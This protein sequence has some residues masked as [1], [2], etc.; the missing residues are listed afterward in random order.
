MGTVMAVM[1]AMASRAKNSKRLLLSLALLAPV[2]ASAGDWKF[3]SGMTLSERYSD[4]VNLAVTG[5]ERADWITEVTPSV[6]VRREGARLKVN[7]DYSLQGLLYADDANNNK[8]R[9]SLNGRAN[10]EFVEE[11]LYLDATARIS[12]ELINQVN[13]G[14]LGDAVGIGNTTSVGAYSLSPYLKHRF[15][16]TATVEARLSH[17]GVFIG[18]SAVSDTASTRY[19]FSAVSGNNFFPLSWSAKYN[20]LDNKSDAA[21][22]DGSSETASVNARY[23]L[24]RK[25]GLLANANM[26]KNDFTGVAARVRDYSSYG[27]GVFYTPSRKFSMDALYNHSDNGDYLSGSVTFNPTPRTTIGAT[28]TKRAYGRSYGLNLAHRTRQSNWRLSYQDDLT[29]SQQQFLNFVGSVD[30]YTCPSGKEYRAVGAPPSDPVN[31]TLDGV[32]RVFSQTQLNETYLA[33]NL[34]GNVSY[35]LRRNTWQLSLF[36]NRR[37]LQTSGGNDTTRGLQASWSLRPAAHTTF[38][39]T[40]GMSHVD[41]TIGPRQDDLW[42]LG[43]VATHQFKP[44]V[45]GSVEARHQERKSKPASDDYSENSVAARLNLTF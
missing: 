3:T 35:S 32:G 38:T 4:N 12:Q 28:S 14:G 23:Q 7:A 13:A 16:S 18:D 44:K 24:S 27:F 5:S 17:D 43:L 21:A 2:M 22:N 45:S 41:S 30:V 39:L 31:C 29:T 33:K 11:W 6:S 9:Q 25:F 36:N 34:I 40:G 8:V 20:K 26:E 15:G 10:A 19:Q 1:V 42:N 37:E